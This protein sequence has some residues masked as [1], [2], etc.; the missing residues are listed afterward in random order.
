MDSLTHLREKVSQTMQAQIH[1]YWMETL[2]DQLIRSNDLNRFVVIRT[3][4]Y[5]DTD[6]YALIQDVKVQEDGTVI[7]YADNTDGDLAEELIDAGIPAD[8]VLKAY[9]PDQ[10]DRLNYTK[11]DSPPQRIAA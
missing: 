3:G 1:G 8:K 4:W 5:R 6:H 11:S 9:D 10:V 2:Q 7:I